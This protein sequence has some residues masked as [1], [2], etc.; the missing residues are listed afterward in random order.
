MTPRPLSPIHKRIA[1]CAAKVYD[2]HLVGAERV[3]V[4]GGNV[5]AMYRLRD[6]LIVVAF[7][8][9]DDLSDWARNFHFAGSADCHQGFEEAGHRV[10]GFVNSIVVDNPEADVVLT[11]HS[12]GGAI[13][14]YLG[15]A[16]GLEAV[17]LGSPRVWKRRYLKDRKYTPALLTRYVASGDFVP[18]VPF[19]TLGFRHRGKELLL[20]QDGLEER[21]SLLGRALAMVRGGYYGWA[22]HSI[23]RYMNLME[24]Q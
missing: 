19:L 14:D 24:K 6:D 11:G 10:F 17:T 16:M 23:D 3:C 12:L 7:R 2:A 5:G 9:S 18:Y 21:G 22:A 4:S 20:T 1:R 8:G 15:Y 13:A